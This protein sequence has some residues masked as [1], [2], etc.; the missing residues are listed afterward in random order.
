MTQ[1]TYIQN[2]A[3]HAKTQLRPL[4]E[5]IDRDGLYPEAYLRQ[6]GK[7]GGFAGAASVKDGGLGLG[8]G[9]QIDV[10]RQVG[11]E[12]GATAFSVWCQSAC[13]WY[14]QQS[15]RQQVKDKYWQAVLQGDL[16]AGTGMS[17]TVKHLANIEKHLLKAQKTAN[18]YVINGSL[19]WVSNIGENHVWAAT[20]QI[21]DTEFVMFMV[22]AQHEGVTLR[23]CPEFCGLEGTRTFAIRFKDVVIHEDDLLADTHQFADFIQ[24][25]KPGFILLQVG[26]GAGIADACIDI[27]HQSNLLSAHVNEYLDLNESDSQDALSAL[28]QETMALANL[29]ERHEVQPLAI[30]KNRL[31]A[32]ELTLAAAQSAALHAGAKGYL[33]RHPAQRRTREAM[34]VAIVTPAIKH[35][36]KEIHALEQETPVQLKTA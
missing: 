4:A 27:M 35:L 31:S 12:C 10:I 15:R 34:F 32:S 5:Q 36:R 8:L 25:I 29:A 23:E 30:L 13:A 11:R 21:S 20:A 33:M 3:E 24:A 9:T 26:I 14:L 17:N 6:L 18:G 22:S 16:L 1:E 19:P 28:W 7:L 2:I